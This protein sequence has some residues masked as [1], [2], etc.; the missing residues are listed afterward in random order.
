MDTG[1]AVSCIP[2]N[3]SP[4][5]Q[6]GDIITFIQFEEGNLLSET[7]NLLS[8]TCDNTESGNES[9]DNLTMPQFFIEEEMDPMSSSNESDAEL[10]FKNMLEDISD[11][12]QSHLR[13]NRRDAYYK[14]R[15]RIKQSQAKW[16]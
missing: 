2:Y 11:G 6:T 4:R 16:K 7:Q 1:T 10:M 8:E 14:I 15:D 9:D 13:V 3:I 5:K 12:S